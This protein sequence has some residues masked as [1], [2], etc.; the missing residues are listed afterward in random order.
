MMNRDATT[1]FDGARFITDVLDYARRHKISRRQL[2]LAADLDLGATLAVLRGE[3]C[4]SLLVAC[5]L[6]DVADLRLDNYRIHHIGNP[7]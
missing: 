4:P 6:A 1:V 5:S 2:C 3:R 7:S